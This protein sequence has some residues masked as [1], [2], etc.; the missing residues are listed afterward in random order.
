MIVP[1]AV[2]QGFGP[3]K[4]AVGQGFSPAFAGSERA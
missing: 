1:T 3:A 2:G 4:T